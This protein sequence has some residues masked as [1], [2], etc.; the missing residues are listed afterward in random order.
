MSEEVAA[1]W[2]GFTPPTLPSLSAAGF[3]RY[4]ARLGGRDL[5]AR[6]DLTHGDSAAVYVFYLPPGSPWQDDT[7]LVEARRDGLTFLW[8]Q[9]GY[10]APWPDETPRSTGL[11]AVS[12]IGRD[13]ASGD[14]LTVEVGSTRVGVQH[15]RGVTRLAWTHRSGDA[16][17]NVTVMSGRS[18]RASVEMLVRDLGA[19]GLG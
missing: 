4:V 11:H 5:I 1:E 7:T 10:G 3:G 17:F 8:L 9:T 15:Q 14:F 16:A 13:P 2:L 18:P 19:L 12:A 6:A